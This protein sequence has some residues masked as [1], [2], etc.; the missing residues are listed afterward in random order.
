YEKE[1]KRIDENQCVNK[2]EKEYENKKIENEKID[3]DEITSV[4]AP[5]L[6]KQT[7]PNGSYTGAPKNKS[8]TPVQDACDL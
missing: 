4:Y 5:H 8:E 7:D 6:I 2:K 3:E 1:D